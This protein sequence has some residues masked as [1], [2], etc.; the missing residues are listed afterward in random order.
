MSDGCKAA[1]F[2]IAKNTTHI[3]QENSALLSFNVDVKFGTCGIVTL[4][5]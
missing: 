1:T 2:L 5:T 3:N 4:D